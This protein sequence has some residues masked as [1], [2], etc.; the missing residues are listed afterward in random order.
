MVWCKDRKSR[1]L[2]FACVGALVASL[3]VVWNQSSGQ[4]SK[5]DSAKESAE[6]PKVDD[7]AKAPD[8]PGEAAAADAA[9]STTPDGLNKTLPATSHALDTIWVM[10][11]GFLVMWMQAGFALVE[12]GLTR[13]KNAV[14][15]CMKNLLDYCFG[16]LRTGLSALASCSPTAAAPTTTGAG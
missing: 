2:A 6:A 9:A 10:V 12:T 4:D 15:I 16:A 1:I 14:N 13:A 3:S 5:A 7:A 11:T 8:E